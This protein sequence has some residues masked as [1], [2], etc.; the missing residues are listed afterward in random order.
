MPKLLENPS[1][2]ASSENLGWESIIV[3]FILVVCL[4]KPQ[5]Y[6]LTNM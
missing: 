3:G 6:R 1:P 2:I 4:N 5:E